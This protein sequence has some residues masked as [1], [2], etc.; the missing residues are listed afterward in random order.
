MPSLLQLSRKIELEGKS[1]CLQAS[2]AQNDKLTYPPASPIYFGENVI[3]MEG[4]TGIKHW[5]R[6]LFP[7]HAQ[8]IRKVILAEWGSY[9]PEFG[10]QYNN[11]FKRLKRLRMLQSLV[12]V[13]DENKLL[14]LQLDKLP[15]TN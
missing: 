14:R 6:R 11:D 5:F 3:Q 7:R 4:W 10:Y 12:V 1:G 8:Q 9:Y 13:V 2:F 15:R